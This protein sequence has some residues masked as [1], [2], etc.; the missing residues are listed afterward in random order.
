MISVKGV[1][2]IVSVKGCAMF[3]ADLF[4][5]TSSLHSVVKDGFD[6]CPRESLANY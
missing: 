4:L 5:S 6:V 2:I 1:N 3:F